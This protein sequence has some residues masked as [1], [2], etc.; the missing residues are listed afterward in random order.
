MKTPPSLEVDPD[1]TELYLKIPSNLVSRP[2]F[3]VS[4]HPDALLQYRLWLTFLL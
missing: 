1:P 2:D 3:K 4:P